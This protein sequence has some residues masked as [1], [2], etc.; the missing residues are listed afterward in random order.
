MARWKLLARIDEINPEPVYPLAGH[1]WAARTTRGVRA[2]LEA[3][4]GRVPPFAE[5][6]CFRLVRGR[7]YMREFR[8]SP[9]AL[10]VAT[11]DRPGA[12][13]VRRA[14]GALARVLV[15]VPR[16]AALAVRAPRRMAAIVAG[17]EATFAAFEAAMARAP[18]DRLDALPAEA[19]VRWGME[20]ADP[21]FAPAFF[22]NTVLN[23]YGGIVGDLLVEALGWIVRRWAGDDGTLFFRLLGGVG[24]LRSTELTTGLVELADAAR[25]VPA[26]AAVVRGDAPGGLARLREL[27][28]AADFLARFERFLATQGHRG[29]QEGGGL[30]RRW[31]EQPALVLGLVRT[32]VRAP[33]RPDDGAA[34]ARERAEAAAAVERRLGR[35]RALRRALFRWVLRHAHEAIRIRENS[36]CLLVAQSYRTR[37]TGLELGRRLHQRGLI[38]PAED[39]VLFL[40][41]AEIGSGIAGTASAET[42]R[43]TI[44][45]RR[46]ERA[47]WL[48]APVPRTVDDAGEPVAPPAPPP[49]APAA[50]PDAPFGG[51][52]ASGGVARGRVRVVVDPEAETDFPEGAILV[53]P[54]ADTAWTPYFY[55]AA[56]VVVE[57]GS[58]LAH[59]ATVAREF[60]VPCVV[61]VADATRRL[62]EGALVE[63]DGDHGTIRIL[64]GALE[65]A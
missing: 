24:G 61:G 55:L 1:D 42:L 59:A 30:A 3:L 19:L 65:A 56:A 6:E 41:L 16:L 45:A 49:R 4:L 11:D 25:A 63:V 53:A 21:A 20:G 9:L 10:V 29:F 31:A 18:V 12:G 64:E 62:A 32:L 17:S 52:P 48:A 5:G 57:T 15:G 23:N 26:V 34:R 13:P 40:T 27:P 58:V 46:A 60:G 44:A 54:Y 2:A 33:A 37:M 38:G 8:V 35:P 47:A 39:E 14:L 7:M 36:K 51:T 28:E 22:A 50:A 43:A